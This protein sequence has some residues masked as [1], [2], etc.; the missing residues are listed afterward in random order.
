MTTDLDVAVLQQAADSFA[1]A[2]RR[3]ELTALNQL[4]C[5]RAEASLGVTGRLR[6]LTDD[7][8]Q[9]ADTLI[10]HGLQMLGTLP[11]T[12]MSDPRIVA[13]ARHGQRALRGPLA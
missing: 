4:E 5:L 3:H 13:A 12:A 7:A 2:A 6:P 9:D 8:Q 10:R 11:L 1:A